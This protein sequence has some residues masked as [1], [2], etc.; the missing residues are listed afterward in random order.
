MKLKKNQPKNSRRDFLKKASA[1]S[2]FYIVPS[3]AITS[4]GYP[5]P[6]GL[7]NIAAIGVGNRGGQVIQQMASPDNP[8]ERRSLPGL[9]IQRYAGIQP[10]RAP[11]GEAMDNLKI[12]NL[13]MQIFMQFVMLII[14][15]HPISLML[16]LNQKPIRIIEK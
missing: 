16:I 13:N 8:V 14:I 1:A 7:I 10:E 4:L 6:N 15:T 5:S 9:I 11:W 3:H 2:L 12:K